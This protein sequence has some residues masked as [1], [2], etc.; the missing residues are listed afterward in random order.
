[1]KWYDPTGCVASAGS[2]RVGAPLWLVLKGQGLVSV[3]EEEE[4]LVCFFYAMTSSRAG[5]R[6]FSIRW[7]LRALKMCSC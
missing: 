7:A 1:M 4:V 3:A 6:P 2:V 5:S